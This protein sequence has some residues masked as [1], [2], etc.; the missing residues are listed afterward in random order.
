VASITGWRDDGEGV[1]VA[2]PSTTVEP[3]IGVAS[4][5]GTRPRSVRLDPL[6]AVRHGPRQWQIEDRDS[7]A[8]ATA[9]ADRNNLPIV[10][11][12]DFIDRNANTKNLG[13][14]WHREMLLEHGEQACSLLLFTIRIDKGLF[15][16]ISEA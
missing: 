3:N 12:L 11:E 16:E 1:A 7:L 4:S 13:G 14:E 10:G 9:R 8:Q 15:D 5:P 6:G 2:V